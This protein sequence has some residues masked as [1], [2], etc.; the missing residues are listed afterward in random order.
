MAYED[1]IRLAKRDRRV[2][3][4]TALSD[5]VLKLVDISSM[6][7]GLDRLNDELTDNNAAG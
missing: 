4:A 6:E 3:L 1:Y 5:E 2:D 7:D